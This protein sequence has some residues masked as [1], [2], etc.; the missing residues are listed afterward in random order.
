MADGELKEGGNSEITFKMPRA[1]VE[2]LLE[3]DKALRASK[4]IGILTPEARI[5][6]W[7][8]CHGPTP[9]S[10]IMAATG[11]SYRGFFTVLRRLKDASMVSAAADA[12]DHRVR[13]LSI[14]Q[15]VC[16]DT[17]S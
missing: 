5:L 14:K 3:F 10:E 8:S 17:P 15:D 6:F 7:I 1:E 11:A 9:V 16:H 12:K 4:G 2:K 13:H